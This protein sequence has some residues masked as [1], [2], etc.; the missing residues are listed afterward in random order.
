MARKKEK[1]RVAGSKLEYLRKPENS[2]F[3]EINLRTTESIEFG[4]ETN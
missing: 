3:V 4:K 2:N 1:F